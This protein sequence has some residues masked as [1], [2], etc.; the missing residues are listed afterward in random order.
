MKKAKSALARTSSDL[1]PAAVLSAKELDSLFAA[2]ES[3]SDSP[4]DSSE[5]QDIDHTDIPSPTAAAANDAS[6]QAETRNELL[7]RRFAQEKT[8]KPRT[9]DEVRA[10]YGRP[11]RG[12]TGSTAASVSGAAGTMARNRDMLAERGE[13]LRQV[14]ERTEELQNEAANFADLAKQLADRQKSSWW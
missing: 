5:W 7:R 1:E 12:T 11:A 14:N 3:T 10:A 13:R 4:G 8:S 6:Q 9:A 2:D